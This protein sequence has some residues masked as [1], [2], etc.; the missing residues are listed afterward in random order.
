[1]QVLAVELD[2]ARSDEAVAITAAIAIRETDAKA[3]ARLACLDLKILPIPV[4]IMAL[5]PSVTTLPA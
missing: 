3:A 5:L 1:V 4:S 2:C